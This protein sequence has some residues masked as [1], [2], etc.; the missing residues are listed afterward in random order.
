MSSYCPWI[1]MDDLKSNTIDLSKKKKRK[2]KATVINYHKSAVLI[3]TPWIIHVQAWKISCILCIRTGYG[4]DGPGSILRNARLIFYKTSRP[5]LRAT[6][7]LI[8]VQ[9]V[10]GGLSPQ[11]K[12]PGHETDPS[13]TSSAEAKQS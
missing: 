1:S 4:L 9:W 8:R 6:Q 5:T 12:R 13:P 10:P 11:V 3:V 7:P 2:W